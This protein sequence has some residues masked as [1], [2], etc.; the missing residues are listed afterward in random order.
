M[1]SRSKVAR[2]GWP[3]RLL[4]ELISA[5][6]GGARLPALPARG[7]DE[8]VGAKLGFNTPRG[9]KLATWK[10]LFEG[11]ATYPYIAPTALARAS[12]YGA[13]M[14]VIDKAGASAAA[15]AWGLSYDFSSHQTVFENARYI[16]VEAAVSARA[17]A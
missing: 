16:V 13:E 5:T 9:E 4:S 2:A 17:A 10:S 6:F 3:Y 15:Q 12:T 1:A 7:D 11:G 14:I 8:P